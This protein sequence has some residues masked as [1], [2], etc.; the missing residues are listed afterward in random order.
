MLW[1]RNEFVQIRILQKILSLYSCFVSLLACSLW[2]D[3]SFLVKY[4]FDKKEFIVLN[5]AFLLRNCKI[6]PVSF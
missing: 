3:I 5:W 4:F 6:L 2:R 1:I